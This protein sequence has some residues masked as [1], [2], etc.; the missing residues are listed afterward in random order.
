KFFM[1]MAEKLKAEIMIYGHIH[2]AYRKDMGNKIF[3][4]AGSVG[5]PKDGDCRACVTLIEINPD[6]VTT[7]FRRITYD[8]DKTASAIVS[9]GLPPY[10]ADRLR[11]GA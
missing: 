4:N 10:F 5:K 1:K 3:I 11:E 7:D 2:K 8:I 6:D 9:A